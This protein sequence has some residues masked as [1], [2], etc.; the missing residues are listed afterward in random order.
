MW[1]DV[2]HIKRA[3]ISMRHLL[4]VVNH[5]NMELHQFDVKT[6]FLHGDLEGSI[7]MTQPEG[8]ILSEN[9]DKV[10]LLKRS[11]Y[12]LKKSPGQWYLKFNEYMMGIDFCRSKYDSCVNYK[13][14]ETR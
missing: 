1:P 7:F 11:L 2:S 12:G 4:S 9:K 3:L 6:A 8:F 13:K 10:C 5:F 14:Y